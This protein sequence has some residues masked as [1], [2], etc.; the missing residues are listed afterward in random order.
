MARERVDQLPDGV[1]MEDRVGVGA[2]DDLTPRPGHEVVQ[3]ARF[4][5]SPIE[6]DHPK[7]RRAEA[8]DHLTRSIRGAV[9]S[10]EDLEML[11]GVVELEEISH[12]FADHALL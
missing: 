4:P 5:S 6:S 9:G 8:G 7:A 1:A 11:H 10:D 3:D 12:A 2:H